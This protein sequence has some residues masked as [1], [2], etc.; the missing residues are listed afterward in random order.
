MLGKTKKMLGKTKKMLGKTRIMLGKTRKNQEMLGKT[1]KMLG[2]TRKNQEKKQETA[3]KN[4]QNTRKNQENTRG[5][6]NKFFKT[7]FV[8]PSVPGGPAGSVRPVRPTRCFSIIVPEHSTDV[9]PTPRAAPWMGRGS[10][11]CLYHLS[12]SL[13]TIPSD[14]RKKGGGILI[15]FL[16]ALTKQQ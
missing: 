7:I 16:M 6:K 2:T 3:R 8:R 10:V 5:K 11:G 15:D 1:R 9:P 4:Y 12:L 13:I 14:Q